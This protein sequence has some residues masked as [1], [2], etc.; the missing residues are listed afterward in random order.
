MKKIWKWLIVIPVIIGMIL[1][2]FFTIKNGSALLDEKEKLKN[3]FENV[4]GKYAEVTKFYTFGTSLNIEGK[5]SGISKDNYEG[6]R[7]IVT[8]GE[9]Y[10]KEY[11]LKIAFAENELLFSFENIN[12]AINLDELKANNK[13]YIKIR[14]KLNNNKSYKYYLLSNVSEYKDIEYYTL[15]KDGKNNKVNVKFSKL[16]Y[17]DKEYKY[18]G[19]IVSETTLPDNVYDFVIDPAKGGKDKGETYSGQTEADLMLDYGKALKSALEN[20][21]YKVKLTRDDES[22]A[23]FTQDHYSENGRISIACKTKAKYMISLHV[24]ATKYYGIEVY[25]PNDVDLSLARTLAEN[26][27]NGSNLDFSNFQARYKLED[28]IY[29]QNFDEAGIE[30]RAQNAATSGYEPYNIT[31]H[32]SELYTIREVGGIATNAF[33]DGRNKEYSKNEYYN[34][35]QGIECYQIYLGGI[36]NDLETLLNQKESI[37]NAISSAF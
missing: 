29:M 17:N 32:T 7:L 9:N 18:L 22:S 12:N 19:L 31:T 25:T 16:N 36:K 23:N 30:K 28:G 27:Y 1:A 20:K 21:G 35:N 8:D 2:V 4:A 5:I 14:L 11:K 33:V 6:S 15:T 10:N 13:Y 3:V 26:I 24:N 34:S 37:V